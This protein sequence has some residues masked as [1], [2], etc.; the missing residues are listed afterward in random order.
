MVLVMFITLYT[1]RVI[2]KALGVIDYGV[3]NVVG[4]IATIFSFVSSALTVSS[5]RFLSYELG[6][7]NCDISKTY[8]SILHAYL[9]LLSS[10]FFLT[11]LL[12]IPILN[13][14]LNIPTNRMYAAHWV[15][16]SSIF[17]LILSVV[18]SPFNAVLMAHEQMKGYAYISIIEVIIK[19]IIA[20]A[21]TVSSYDKLIFYAI[22]MF[23]AKLLIVLSFFIYTEKKISTCSIKDIKRSQKESL[24]EIFSFTSW[25]F[26]GSMSLVGMNQGSNILLNIFFGASINT[27]RGIAL[28]VTNAVINFSSSV[29][30]ALNPVI[31]KA[32]AAKDYTYFNNLLLSGS[33]LSF[34]LL[35]FISVPILFYCNDILTLWLGHFPHET[36]VFCQL[37]LVISMIDSISLYMAA[38]IQATGKIKKYQIIIS[39][40]IMLNIPFSYIALKNGASCYSVYIINIGISL[41]SLIIRLLLTQETIKCFS[42]RFFLVNLLKKLI[43][44]ICISATFLYIVYEYFPH[45]TFW[46]F[47]I[48]AII[49]NSTTIYL[50][51]LSNIEKQKILKLRTWK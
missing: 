45:L 22:L 35:Y 6:K 51:G 4:G 42:V 18:Q 7:Q 26:L 10:I 46:K 3:Y 15:L 12:G 38:A 17:I 36:I 40:I 47:C 44:T 19:L 30:G 39:I 16:Q 43:P 5:Q 31:T 34:M 20:Y 24:R 1:S 50:V 33:K 8:G 32:F 37:S 2:L 28:Q 13:H 11:E 29:Q 27:A 48:I 9:I 49:I 14:I 41:V 23:F 25:N 21:L